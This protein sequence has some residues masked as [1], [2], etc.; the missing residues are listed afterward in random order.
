[1]IREL[2]SLEQLRSATGDDP[3]LVWTAQGLQG[4]AR[5]W[6]LGDA[7]VS[8][9][10]GISRADAMG[11]RGDP[12][13]LA[14]LVR[15][16]LAE[17]GPTFRPLGERAL[18]REVVN[19]M[20]ELRLVAAGF[21]WRTL[22]KAPATDEPDLAWLPAARDPEVAALLEEHAPGS[23]AQPGAPGVRR[24]AG[25]VS[26]GR[27]AAVGADAWSAPGCGLLSSVATVSDLRGR[28]LAERLCRWVSARFIEEYGRAALMVYD[29]NAP[30]V[31]LYDRLGYSAMPMAASEVV[32]AGS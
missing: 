18:V 32:P 24:W 1:M 28:R 20:P 10:F 22:D 19:R 16:A 4:G 14:L 6:A 8:S 9:A 17:L 27:L 11:V 23:F 21:T 5:A 12:E 13:D 30:A 15:H 26:G 31:R 3:L 25:L 7:V 2:T 29:A